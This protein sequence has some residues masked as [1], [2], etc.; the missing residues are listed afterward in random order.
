MD[1]FALEDL[2]AGPGL[3]QMVIGI[4]L[5]RA[6]GSGQAMLSECIAPGAR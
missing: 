1:A 5:R 3:D 2:T 6:I 4:Q